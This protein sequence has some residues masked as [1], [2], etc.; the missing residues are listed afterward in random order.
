MDRGR[1]QR[2]DEGVETIIDSSQRITKKMGGNED[3]RAEWAMR[4]NERKKGKISREGADF[5]RAT[6]C[7][8]VC[9]PRDAI[10]H[11]TEWE[12]SFFIPTA[13]FSRGSLVFWDIITR[14]D[15]SSCLR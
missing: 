13:L 12:R 14:I 11:I 10:S 7:D 4:E 8:A 15:K 3:L 2:E 1:I 5:I 6:S 9:N